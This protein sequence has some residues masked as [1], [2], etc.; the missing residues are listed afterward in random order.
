LSEQVKTDRQTVLQQPY[1]VHSLLMYKLE[2]VSFRRF[3]SWRSLLVK[4]SLSSNGQTTRHRLMQK[5]KCWLRN[6]SQM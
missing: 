4:E 1:Y 2:G 5:T 3:L 6:F